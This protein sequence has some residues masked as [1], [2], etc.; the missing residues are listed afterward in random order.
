METSNLREQKR[1]W[2]REYVA[3]NRDKINAQRRLRRLR[4]RERVNAQKRAWNKKWYAANAEYARRKAR[5][6]YRA[7]KGERIPAP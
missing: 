4:D 2:N 3:A 7:R 6:R 1:V 5:D